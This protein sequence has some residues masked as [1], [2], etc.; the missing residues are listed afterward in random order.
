MSGIGEG[1]GYHLYPPMSSLS[2]SVESLAGNKVR[3]KVGVPAAEFEKAIDSAFRKLAREVKIPGFRPGKAPRQLLEAR[4]G[5]G[6]AREQA[7][8]DALPEYYAEAVVAEDIDVIAPPEIE[9]TAGEDDGDVAFDAVVEIR[10]V[11]E[12]QGYDGVRVEVPSTRRSTRCESGSPTSR[13]STGRSPTATTR[14]STSRVPRRASRGRGRR[15][16]R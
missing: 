3:L 16:T 7:L 14:R 10:P 8:R 9:M 2:T 1:S 4:L 6:V 15:S 12:L 5:P 13:T 11:V